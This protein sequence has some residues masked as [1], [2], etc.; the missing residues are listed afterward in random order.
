MEI[1][2]YFFS[3]FKRLSVS[4]LLFKHLIFIPSFLFFNEVKSF[5]DHIIKILGFFV[6]SPSI[7]YFMWFELEHVIFHHYV[8]FSI[9]IHLCF[10]LLDL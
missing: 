5:L 1:S 4:L 3:A 2:N 6:N 9:S 7:F 8:N 10:H